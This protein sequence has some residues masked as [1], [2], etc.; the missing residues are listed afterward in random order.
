MLVALARTIAY[1][2]KTG[3]LIPIPSDPSVHQVVARAV[4]FAAQTNE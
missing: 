2:T 1:D 4:E 3:D